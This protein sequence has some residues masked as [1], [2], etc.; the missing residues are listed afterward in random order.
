MAQR[1]T[2]RFRSTSVIRLLVAALCLLLLLCC[3]YL[4]APTIHARYL[5]HKLETL[6]LGH[7]TFEDAQRLATQIG[8]KR[9]TFGP[10]DRSWCEWDAR[11]DNSG[12]PRWWRGSGEAFRVSFDVKDSVV[13]RKLTGFGIGKETET[14]HP[15]AVSLEE[16]ESWRSDRP[17]GPV[18]AGWIRTDLYRYYVFQ[19]QMTPNAPAADRRRYTSFNFNC[20][21]KY[22]GCKDA[23]ELLPTADPPPSD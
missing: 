19:V 10:C 14:F 18:Q 8:A 1:K 22:K 15:S 16:Q 17:R 4:L 23:R 3:A 20:F 11:M 5:F 13:V 9:S 21:W 7:S 6:K 2:S 12:L